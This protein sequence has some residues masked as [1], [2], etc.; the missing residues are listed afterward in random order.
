MTLAS[1]FDWA[2]ERLSC[3]YTGNEARILVTRLLASF[4]DLPRHQL[5]LNWSK[6]LSEAEKEKLLP[7]IERLASGEPLQYI[8]GCQIF[9]NDVYFVNPSALI[10]R[11]ETE[12]LVELALQ[13]Y[14]TLGE[15]SKV[16][17]LDIGTGSGCISIAL[18][19]RCP[20]ATIFA[21]DNS[22]AALQIAAHNA[23][24]HRVN[25]HFL[26]ADILQAACFQKLKELNFLFDIIIANPPYV[27][28]SEKR[29]LHPNISFEPPQAIFVTEGEPIIYYEKIAAL[30]RYFLKVDGRVFLECHPPF[31]QSVADQLKKQF[32]EPLSIRKDMNGRFRFVVARK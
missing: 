21:L 23:N 11:P 8:E 7:L 2:Q 29:F 14:Q 6:I 12:E 24:K 19:L 18:A 1:F 10:P 28:L 13:Y 16:N 20:R 27:P 9:Y 22:L 25:I 3:L 15:L 30:A 5:F 17:I 26:K 4:L 32:L 31:V